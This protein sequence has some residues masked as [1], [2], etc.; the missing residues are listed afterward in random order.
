M[1]WSPISWC[2]DRHFPLDSGQRFSVLF[3][4]SFST[5]P[6]LWF[7][8]SLE[9]PGL[10][11]SGNFFPSFWYKWNQSL[12]Y[13]LDFSESS[14]PLTFQS[15]G[16]EKQIQSQ[17]S[18]ETSLCLAYLYTAQDW[19]FC[20]YPCYTTI[21]IDHLNKNLKVY[22]YNITFLIKEYLATCEEN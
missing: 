22:L 21:T 19:R 7:Q 14:T 9:K 15:L 13:G 8:L 10:L 20:K 1:I 4:S 17:L 3:G 12:H 5:V 2:M 16:L 11:V 6:G 18:L